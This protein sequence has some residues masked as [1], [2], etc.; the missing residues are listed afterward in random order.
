MN[1]NTE[2]QNFLKETGLVH[3]ITDEYPRPQS[4]IQY[5][6]PGNAGR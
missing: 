6:D 5:N 3:R 1:G 2:R 4:S